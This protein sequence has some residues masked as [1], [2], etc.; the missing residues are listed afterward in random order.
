MLQVAAEPIELPDIEH[1][2]FAER[3]KAGCLACYRFRGRRDKVLLK[4]MRGLGADPRQT[5]PEHGQMKPM[6]LEIGRLRRVVAKLKA[7]RDIL[8]EAA[9]YFARLTSAVIEGPVRDC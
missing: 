7:E 2:P 3:L 9:A 5:F 1:I 8:K 4:W 6:Q